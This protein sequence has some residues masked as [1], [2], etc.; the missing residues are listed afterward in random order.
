MGDN[1]LRHYTDTSV[2]DGAMPIT[3]GAYICLKAQ[4][5]SDTC[6]AATG[7]FRESGMKQDESSEKTSAGREH[8]FQARRYGCRTR[9]LGNGFYLPRAFSGISRCRTFI[10]RCRTFHFPKTI[11]L[12]LSKSLIFNMVYLSFPTKEKGRGTNGGQTYYQ[13]VYTKCKCVL[14]RY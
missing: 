3:G 11:V 9:P 2:R 1:I 7:G 12:K 6:V 8:G 13:Q 10:S 14:K 5:I 4:K